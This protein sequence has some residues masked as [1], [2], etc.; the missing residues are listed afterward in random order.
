LTLQQRQGASSGRLDDGMNM[1][2][3][4]SLANKILAVLKEAAAEDRL[5]VA[6]HLLQALEVLEGEPCPG[7]SLG[8]AYLLVAR[9]AR[10]RRHPRH[11]R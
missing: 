5:D 9:R 4:C 6:E 7:S 1:A 3:R 8:N 10:G 11:A 2:A